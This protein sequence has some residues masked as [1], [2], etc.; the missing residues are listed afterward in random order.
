[1]SRL[2][3]RAA[4]VSSGERWRSTLQPLSWRRR[5]IAAISCCSS[6]S[7]SVVSGAGIAVGV[8]AGALVAVVGLA[9]WV[10]VGAPVGLGGALVGVEMGEGAAVDV[11]G[12]TLVAAGARVE[13][14]EAVG[15]NAAGGLALPGPAVLRPKANPPMAPTH[16][17]SS[18]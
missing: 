5:L 13:L 9:E 18:A 12:A 15:T 6:V 11:G 10:A 1:M 8:G 16:S 7:A 3:A 17:D 4:L 2:W 14:G